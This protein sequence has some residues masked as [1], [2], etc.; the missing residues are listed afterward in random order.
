M[1]IQIGQTY[2]VLQD[3]E[4]KPL[5]GGYVFVGKRGQ[6]PEQNPIEIYYDAACTIPASNPVRTLNGYFS[7]NGT[8]VNVFSK[9]SV[10]SVAVYDR[11]RRLVWNDFDFVGI[12]NGNTASPSNGFGYWLDTYKSGGKYPLNSRIVR[13]DGKVVRAT[14]NNSSKNPNV[15]MTGWVL[16]SDASQIFDS[17]G[18]TQQVINDNQAFKNAET[19]SLD[20]YLRKYSVSPT[21]DISSILNQIK[22]DGVKKLHVK[23]REYT[24]NS[25]IN[26]TSDFEFDNETGV[27]FNFGSSGAFNAS[28]SHIEIGT[29]TSNITKDVSSSFTASSVAGLSV[30]DWIC[31][32]CTTD[33]SYSPYRDYYRKGEFMEIAGISGTTITF[34][35]RAFDNYSLSEPVKLLKINPV[36][37]KWNQITTKSSETNQNVPITIDYARNFSVE[38]FNTTG[39]LYAG[40]RLRRCLNVNIGV[41][42]ASNTSALNTLN[43][44]IQ[45]SNCQ[46][47]RY[48]GGKNNSTRHAFALGGDGDIGCVPCRKGKV[49]GATLYSGFDNTSGAD[50]HG[51]VEHVTYDH[52]TTNYATMSGSDNTYM[53]CDIYERPTQGCVISSEPRGG[54]LTLINN[55]YYTSSGL[56]TWAL[57]HV[58]IAQQLKSDLTVKVIGGTIVGAGGASAQIVAVRQANS[59]NEDLTNKV[60]VHITGGITCNFADLSMWARIEHATSGLRLIPVGYII[61]DDVVNTSATASP[62]LVYPSPSTVASGVLTRQMK[63]RGS[64]QL[65]SVVNNT[66]TRAEVI[67][68]KYK[69]SKAP[70][71]MV[72][73]GNITGIAAWDAS[74]FNEDT[75]ADVLRV[76][77]ACNSQITLS[78]LRPAVLW[79]KKVV[80]AKT[81]ALN[82][83]TSIDEI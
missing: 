70:F 73:V 30:G 46:N 5:D 13:N 50:M 62:Y 55:K 10:S 24:V 23:A 41:N 2:Q 25:V 54:Q 35:G 6:N 59:L 3:I 79:N 78:S 65:T 60:N 38:N 37:F 49:Y 26:F 47:F 71:A 29:L 42:S 64:V 52:C 34:Y 82:W 15:D 18:V 1:S 44:A 19:V 68:L 56:N 58:Q 43:Y 67:N 51:N 77:V 4:G 61:V 16:D 40:V 76:P 48:L 57:I 7:R 45:V 81:F 83:Q 28:G 8:P 63:Q 11:N 9:F 22:A 20:D 12:G 80:T 72:S 39:G 31:L 36:K 17:S 32:Y 21:A 69:Y 33:Y 74:F 27:V 14:V 66:A 53:N 75:A